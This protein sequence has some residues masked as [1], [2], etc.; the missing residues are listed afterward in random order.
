MDMIH[1]A[2]AQV[3]IMAEPGTGGLL[4]WMKD[5]VISA[6]LLIAGA[7]A[8]WAGATGKVAKVVTIVAGVAVALGVVGLAIGDWE[9][10][11]SWIAGLFGFK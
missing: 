11:G 2:A 5:N 4:Q 7:S 1:L 3:D 9:A 10:I 8:L 6:I